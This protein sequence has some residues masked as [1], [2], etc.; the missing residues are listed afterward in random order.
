[1]T[2]KNVQQYISELIKKDL[3]NSFVR[4]EVI[5]DR[6]GFQLKTYYDIKEKLSSL[7]FVNPF[8]ESENLGTDFMTKN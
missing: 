3:K 1:M 2:S 7:V 5:C 6:K 8:N 4:L